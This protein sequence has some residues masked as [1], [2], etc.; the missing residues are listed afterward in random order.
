MKKIKL[1]TSLLFSLLSLSILAQNYHELSRPERRTISCDNVLELSDGNIISLEDHGYFDNVH[2]NIQGVYIMKMNNKAELLD[3][4]Y[5]D[6][7]YEFTRSEL[8]RNPYKEGNNL[9]AKLYYNK[10]NTQYQYKAVF[11]DDNLD[12]TETID[13][14]INCE[15]VVLNDGLRLFLDLN[16]N[17]MIS[18]RDIYGNYV[19]LTMD[20]YGNLIYENNTQISTEKYR[21][22]HECMF[23]YDKD[24]ELYGFFC[25]DLDHL[26]F[27][28]GHKTI[29]I[30]DNKYNTIASYS[31]YKLDDVKINPTNVD[32]MMIEKETGELI[33]VSSV[34]LSN[35]VSHSY[36]QVTEFD[37][38]MNIIRYRR[39]DKGA[40]TLDEYMKPHYSSISLRKEVPCI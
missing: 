39:I 8:I 16:N 29:F 18:A 38:E 9:F 24:E 32:P 25:A 35:N 1:L 12:I 33:M 10:E 4:L 20:L 34:G 37:K 28:D 5:I 30:L 22:L 27:E 17:W 3:S 23:V 13:V 19:F 2:W 6:F 21:R 31:L 15:K 14:P 11:F 40:I 36:L 7:P 26:V